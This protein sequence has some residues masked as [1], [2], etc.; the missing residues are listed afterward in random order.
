MTFFVCCYN[1]SSAAEYP[2][3]PKHFHRKTLPNLGLNSLEPLLISLNTIT[4]LVHLSFFRNDYH[5]KQVNIC[6]ETVTKAGLL[7][8]LGSKDIFFYHLSVLLVEVSSVWIQW[9]KWE[10]KRVCTY[11]TWLS[12]HVLLPGSH[13]LSSCSLPTGGYISQTEVGNLMKVWIT[14]EQKDTKH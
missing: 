11:C 14:V 3:S 13:W 2:A 4:N 7:S 12:T 5:T 6:L 10:T 1:F 9:H 8:S